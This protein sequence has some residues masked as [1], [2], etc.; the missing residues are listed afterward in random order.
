ML[1]LVNANK[2]LRI[3]SSSTCPGLVC[4]H[5]VSKL[6]LDCFRLYCCIIVLSEFSGPAGAGSFHL[7]IPLMLH[8][9]KG[10]ELQAVVG[11]DLILLY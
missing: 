9:T 2:A 8:S 7:K 10:K 1:F 3:T 11:E 4:S 5:L 6:Y